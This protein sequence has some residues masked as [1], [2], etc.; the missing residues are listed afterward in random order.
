MPLNL[1]LLLRLE[2]EIDEHRVN[3]WTD[4]TR[5]FIVV[6]PVFND[7]QESLVLLHQS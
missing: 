6:S 2:A 3:V 7:A 1:K 5:R 4:F